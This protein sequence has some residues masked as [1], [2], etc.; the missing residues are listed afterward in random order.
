MKVTALK[1]FQT[2]SY[3]YVNQ[4]QELIVTDEHAKHFEKYGLASIVNNREYDTKVIRER[5]KTRKK[6]K[7]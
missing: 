3:G 2:T 1:D 5:P 7:K 4:G 6:G